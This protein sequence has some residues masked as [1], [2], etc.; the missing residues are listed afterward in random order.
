MKRR[1]ASHTIKHPSV[2]LVR[3]VLQHQAQH[4]SKTTRKYA[5]KVLKRSSKLDLDRLRMSGLDE[6]YLVT[7][8][9]IAMVKKGDSDARPLLLNMSKHIGIPMDLLM[10]SGLPDPSVFEGR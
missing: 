9:L 6:H 2:P 5:R 10:R 7:S 3:K 8:V 4:R 1:L